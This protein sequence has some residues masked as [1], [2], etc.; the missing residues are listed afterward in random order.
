MSQQQPNDEPQ[1][2]NTGKDKTEHEKIEE[3]IGREWREDLSRRQ[4]RRQRIEE[5]LEEAAA[6]KD[7]A[8]EKSIYLDKIEHDNPRLWGVK[9]EGGEE[10]DPAVHPDRAHAIEKSIYRDKI[11]HDNPRLWGVKTS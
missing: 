9:D 6:K 7:E 2:I 10:V 3:A 4:H 11:G 5:I 1:E 8:V